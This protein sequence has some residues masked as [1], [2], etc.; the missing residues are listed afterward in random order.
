MRVH[1]QAIN[2]LIP[3]LHCTGIVPCLCSIA[4]ETGNKARLVGEESR[5]SFLSWV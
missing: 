1:T 3:R 5:V 4:E 2:S